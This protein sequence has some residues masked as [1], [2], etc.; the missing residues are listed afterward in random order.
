MAGSRNVL[1]RYQDSAYDPRYRLKCISAHYDRDARSPGAN[2][3]SAACLQL[4]ALA[5]RLATAGFAHNCV[6]V[7]SDNEEC[8]GKNAASQGSFALAWGIR[9]IRK[10]KPWVFSLDCT[11]RG[12]VPI[13]SSPQTRLRP[14][15]P[16]SAS[17]DPGLFALHS[18]ISSYLDALYGSAWA[19]LP[20][21]YSDNY[22]YILGGL[23]AAAITLLPREEVELFRRGIAENP[24]IVDVL[25]TRE[26]RTDQG[27]RMLDAY[28]PASWK[29]L[30]G[31]GD[32]LASLDPA[33][34][35][36]MA[37]LLDALACAGIPT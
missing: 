5:R 36:V 37:R 14:R 35:P 11:G 28:L 26:F 4:L 32:S 20:T 8:G 15:K 18:W 21:L 6:L 17:A 30:H 7:F 22:G 2:D 3:N 19:C 10:D 27:R 31:P 9:R 29:L 23:A 16:Q 24:V 34:F 1:V 12:E 13:L 25:L 33:S